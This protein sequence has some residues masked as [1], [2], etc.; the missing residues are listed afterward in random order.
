MPSAR[1]HARPSRRAWPGRLW[2]LDLETTGLDPD[3]D[4]IIEIGLVP[5]VDRRIQ[6]GRA[7]SS[8]VR[9]EAYRST[10]TVAHQIMPI[11]LD[12]A[13]APGPTVERL[14]ELV[15]ADPLLLHHATIDLAFLRRLHRRLDLAWP[16]PAVVDTVEL[17]ERRNRRLRQIGETELP[18]QLGEARRAIGLPPTAE[19]RAVDDAVATAEL[20]LALTAAEA[21]GIRR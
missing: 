8:L 5:V 4:H 6:L 7:W 16:G 1:W 13:A 18:L 11:D 3:V 15:G 12:R 19:H 20:W 9:P 21:A 17:L 10:G 2:A 14:W